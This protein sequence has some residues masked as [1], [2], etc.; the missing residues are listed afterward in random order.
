[1]AQLAVSAGRRGR[2][3]G[4]ASAVAVPN[5]IYI[6]RVTVRVRVRVRVKKE[7]KPKRAWV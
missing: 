5:H 7:F 3:F 2:V 6:Y 1:M 4:P